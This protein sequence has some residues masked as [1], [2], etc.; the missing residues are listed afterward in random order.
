MRHKSHPVDVLSHDGESLVLRQV[1]VGG[2]RVAG[3]YER[4]HSALQ[5]AALAEQVLELF[6]LSLIS[7]FNKCDE[8]FAGFG[9]VRQRNGQ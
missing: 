8:R 3:R 1:D 5:G 2:G 7:Y 9:L 4:L 6:L